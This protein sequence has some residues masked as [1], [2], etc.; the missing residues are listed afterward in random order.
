M[1]TKLTTL[2]CLLV[3]CLFVVA[4]LVGCQGQNGTDGKSAYQLW[5]D[6][7]NTG[8]VQD[9]VN[10]LRGENGSNGVGIASVET[11]A[12]GELVLNEIYY[13]II[14]DEILKIQDLKNIVRIYVANGELSRAIGQKKKTKL[15]LI[16]EFSLKEIYFSEDS[17]LSSFEVRVISEER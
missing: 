9:F 16:S 13:N 12:L 3:M 14:K 2:L 17:E 1:K 11:N 15:A 8:T 5:L 10:S 6:Q 4:S 7:G